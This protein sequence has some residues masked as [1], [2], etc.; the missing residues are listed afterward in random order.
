MNTFPEPKK[1][2]KRFGLEEGMRVADFGSGS[3]HYTL[4]ASE[5]VGES[6]IVYAIE[7]Q[8]LLLKKVKNIST[9]EHHKN[10]EV[11]WGDIEK[12]KG[13]KLADGS[14]DV[15]IMSNIFFQLENKIIALSEASR[16]LKPNGRLFFIDWSE[17]FGGLGPQPEFIVSETD[18]KKIVSENNF[19]FER[20]ID[21]GEHHYGLLF[22]KEKV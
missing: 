7:I 9:D 14:V 6:G 20:A 22:R 8:K 12:N 21:V 11:I 2:L 5:L 16:V 17:S 3:G 10:I 4:A 13:S 15:V 19:I 1:N 18:A